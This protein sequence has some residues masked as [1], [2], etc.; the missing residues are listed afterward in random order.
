MKENCKCG[1]PAVYHTVPKRGS[2]YETF[3]T[4]TPACIECDADLK[5]E[6]TS[7]ADC[8][9]NCGQWQAEQDLRYSYRMDQSVC[10]GCRD[11]GEM[12]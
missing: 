10:S 5:E 7:V 3:D 6:T 8:C 12:W 9:E 11:G 1:R 4:A 2:F